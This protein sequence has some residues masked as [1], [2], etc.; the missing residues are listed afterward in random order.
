V[1]KR[2]IRSLVGGWEPFVRHAGTAASF[3]L[4]FLDLRVN[5]PVLADVPTDGAWLFN[6][7]PLPDGHYSPY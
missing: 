6:S 1:E 7:V 4:L 5:L 2:A 3:V